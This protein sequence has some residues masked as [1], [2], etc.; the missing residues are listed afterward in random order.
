MHPDLYDPPTYGGSPAEEGMKEQQQIFG[1]EN[2]D[3]EWILTD[4][5]VWLKNPYYTGEPGPHPE[6]D[7]ETYEPYVAPAKLELVVSFEADE[8]ECP[9]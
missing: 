8:E 9:F 5:D 4:W 6:Q 7:P 3:H 1:A 2:P